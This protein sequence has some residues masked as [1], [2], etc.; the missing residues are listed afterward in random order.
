MG[1]GGRRSKSCLCVTWSDVVL[2]WFGVYPV[3]GP[4]ILRVEKYYL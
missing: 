4:V 2:V 1:P 3:T